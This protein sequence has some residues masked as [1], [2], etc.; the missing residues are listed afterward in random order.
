[1]KKTL[2]IFDFDGTIADTLLIAV[3]I[4]NEVGQEFDLPHVDRDQFMELKHKSVPELMKMAG[5][6][7]LK[8]PLFINQ[9]RKKFRLHLKQVKPIIGMP[10]ILTILKNRGYRMGIVTSNTQ[11]GVN[12]FLHAYGLEHFEFVHAPNSIFD[13]SKTIKEIMHTYH[14][15]PAQVTMIGDE[16]RDVE[17]AHKVGI[18]SIAVTW[19]FNS[20]QLLLT[21]S[22]N[23]LVKNPQDLLTLLN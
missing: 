3:R 16:I 10:E 20:E 8:L 7:W 1:M 14:L 21:G 23:H 22:P 18:E 13:K 9:A 19:G 6:S 11:E 4:I 5:L 17:A 2:L 15:K 12:A